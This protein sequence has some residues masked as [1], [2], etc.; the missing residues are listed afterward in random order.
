MVEILIKAPSREAL[1]DYA[2]SLGDQFWTPETHATRPGIVTSGALPGGGSYFV[3]ICADMVPTGKT[4]KT[5]KGDNVPEYAPLDGC[6]ARVVM[7]GENLFALGDLPMPP[8]GFVV[9]MPT[10][11]PGTP[12][13]YEQPNYGRVL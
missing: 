3:N 13:G 12:D 4:V 1:D 7:N 9:Y 5:A 11:Y 2:K 8:D 6:W 10:G